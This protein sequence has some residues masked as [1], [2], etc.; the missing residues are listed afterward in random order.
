VLPGRTVTVGATV[1][2]VGAA[3]S[4][5]TV[6]LEVYSASG[7][8]VA[9]RAHTGQAFSTRQSASYKWYWTAPSTLGA[10]TVKVAVTGAG[11]APV[12]PVTATAASLTVTR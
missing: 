3:V 8:R 6:T 7:T 5:A 9:Q 10:Y 1:V 4:G 12:Y 2:N 11:G